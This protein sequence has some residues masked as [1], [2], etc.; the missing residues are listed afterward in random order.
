MDMSKRLKNARKHLD[1]TQDTMAKPLGLSQA[2][3]R[4]LELGKVKISTLHV[5]ALE[6]VYK[7][8]SKWLMT[9]DGEMMIDENKESSNQY[10][11]S[12]E[13][14]FEKFQQKELAE[15]FTKRMVEL[16]KLDLNAIHDLMRYIEYQILS[17]T[18]SESDMKKKSP[19]WNGIDRRKKAAG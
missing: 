14:V 6:H 19:Q 16:E 1:L 3:F 8:N 11:E 12:S 5:L 18:S 7:I 4:D 15:E 9:G 2:N 13:S 17:R 10:P